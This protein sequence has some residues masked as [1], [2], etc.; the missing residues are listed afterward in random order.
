MA[1]NLKTSV[2]PLLTSQ[3]AKNNDICI[4]FMGRTKTKP[5]LKR[6]R[7]RNSTFTLGS[8][9]SVLPSSFNTYLVMWKYNSEPLWLQSGPIRHNGAN[10]KLQ[11]KHKNSLFTLQ[12]FHYNYYWWSQSLLNRF[13]LEM[14]A[15]QR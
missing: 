5:F 1:W 12:T 6:K 3:S 13:G 10:N 9:K 2:I 7:C 8:K 14:Y 4:N 11:L 15:F